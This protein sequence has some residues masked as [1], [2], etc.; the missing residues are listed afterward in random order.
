MSR[1]EKKRIKKKQEDFNN[2]LNETGLMI[3]S[4]RLTHF[5]E[6][7]KGFKLHLPS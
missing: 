2:S 5:I 1:Y 3:D 7:K 6:N 4:V